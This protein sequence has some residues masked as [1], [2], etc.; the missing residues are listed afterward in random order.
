[1]GTGSASNDRFHKNA[2]EAVDNKSL[3]FSKR[4]G[5]VLAFT[6]IVDEIVCHEL[7]VVTCAHR[8][9]NFNM[10]EGLLSKLA[11]LRRIKHTEHWHSSSLN[12][13]DKLLVVLFKSR[14][15]HEFVIQLLVKRLR[16][17][18][19]VYHEGLRNLREQVVTF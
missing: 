15:N 18:C 19:L 11:L 12:H 14:N 9:V 10:F 16:S 8:L 4:A 17:D 3:F 7:R 2:G 6:S 13:S 5:S 1:M